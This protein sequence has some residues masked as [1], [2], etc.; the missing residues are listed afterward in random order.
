MSTEFAETDR[1]S[2]EQQVEGERG[3]MVAMLVMVILGVAGIFA[4]SA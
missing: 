4:A 3:M 1:D 2:D